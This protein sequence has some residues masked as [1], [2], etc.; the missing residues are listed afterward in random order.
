[1]LQ[2][3]LLLVAIVAIVWYGFKLV[4]RLDRQRKDK[5][6]RDARKG[7]AE[8]VQCPVCDAYIAEDSRNNCGRPDCPY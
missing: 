8:T 4:G 6:A 5:L 1:M 3:I 7:V 2:K